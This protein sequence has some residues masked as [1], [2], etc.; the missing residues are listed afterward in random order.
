MRRCGYSVFRRA[1]L[2]T[3]L[4]VL[5]T[6]AP[7]SF[8]L[9]AFDLS[10]L[11]AW[12]YLGFLVVAVFWLTR[13]H[14]AGTSRPAPIWPLTLAPVILAALFWTSPTIYAWADMS[15]LIPCAR[16]CF[17]EQTPQ[18]R[19]MDLFRRRAIASPIRGYVVPA[20]S[21]PVPLPATTREARTAKSGAGWLAPDAMSLGG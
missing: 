18:G 5:A 13:A 8:L 11:M 21:C 14:P 3:A 10:R 20:A 4:A 7:V 6:L 9:V 17:K 16:F 12:S 15:H 2:D 19:A 1:W